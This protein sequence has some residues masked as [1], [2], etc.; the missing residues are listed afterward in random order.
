MSG[1]NYPPPPGEGSNAIGNFQI[2]VSPIGDIAHFYPWTTILSQYANSPVLT[3]VILDAAANIDQTQNLNNF[4]DMIWDVA[5]AQDYGLD[6][7]GRIVGVERNLNVQIASFFGFSEAL[8]G[9]LS[10]DS[11][12][13]FFRSPALGFSEAIPGSFTFGFGSFNSQKLWSHD[14]TA[15]GGGAFYDG[16]A[17]TTI[18]RLDDKSYRTLIYAKAAFNITNG[19]SPAINRTLMTLFPGRGNAFVQEGYQGPGNFGFSESRNALTFGQGVFYTGGSVPSM[20]M[21]YV[22]QFP[23][24]PLEYSIVA[25]SGVLPKSVGV[26]A[27]VVITAP[28]PRTLTA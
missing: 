13:V 25:T 22:F 1:P 20:T 7:W 16:Q 17:L 10:F 8:P 15:Q 12:L 28:P 23:L 26:A 5:S 14:G 3:R 6:V 9:S 2:G 27:S 18:Y 24:S 11:T 4:Y 21:S 19:S